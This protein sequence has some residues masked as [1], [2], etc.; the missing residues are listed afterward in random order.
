[1]KSVQPSLLEVGVATEHNT[2]TTNCAG[3]SLSQSSRRYCYCLLLL[4]QL[5]EV[6]VADIPEELA[7]ALVVGR[8][9][10]RPQQL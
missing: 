6:G 8:R 5:L 7:V 9:Q 1:M 10:L 2:T 3:V 4:L